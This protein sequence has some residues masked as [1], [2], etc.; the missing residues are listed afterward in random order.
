MAV[1]VSSRSLEKYPQKVVLIGDSLVY[2]FGDAEGGGWAERLRRQWMD[3][4]NPG[5]ILYNLGVRGDTVEQVFLRLENEFRLRG[6]LRRQ[7]PDRL[8]ISVGLNDTARVGRASGRLMTDETH[9]RQHITDLLDQARQLCEVYFVGMVPVN[10]AAMPYADMLYFSRL[11]QVRYKEITRQACD[12]RDIPYLDVY[13]QWASQ[14]ESW[15]NERLCRDGI[16]PNS[17]GH[18]TL[19]NDISNWAPLANALV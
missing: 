1:S 13:H 19:L 9:F 2:G 6:E 4:E 7:L 16:H 10:E 14:G 15:C 8:I 12:E 5:P 3:P 11:D 18:R 17:L